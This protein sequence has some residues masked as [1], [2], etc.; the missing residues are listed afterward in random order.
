MDNKQQNQ[1]VYTLFETLPNELFMETLSYLTT[2]DAVIAFSNLNCR[3]QCLV[4][5]YCQ[6][7]DFTSIGKS[8]FDLIFQYHNTSR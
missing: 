6:S 3:F 4:F 7:F 8:K 1:N 2:I 5:D